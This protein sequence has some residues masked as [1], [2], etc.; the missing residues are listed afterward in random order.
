M[1]KF[2]ETLTY[3]GQLLLTPLFFFMLFLKWVLLLI[4]APF[5]LIWAVIMLFIS[6][7]NKVGRNDNI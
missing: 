3:I 6:I 7:R 4:T 5:I 2:N 1:K